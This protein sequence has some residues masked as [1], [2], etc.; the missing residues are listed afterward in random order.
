PGARYDLGA[1]RV[2]MSTGSPLSAE[3]FHWVYEAVKDDLQLASI[4]G[5]TDIISCFMLGCPTDPVYAGE[6]QK[7]GLGMRVE[8]WDETGRPVVGQ[9]GELVCTA[10]FVSMPVAFWNDPDGAR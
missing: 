7:R 9:K 2:V 4:S 1:L 8:A 3:L 6:I 5:G 10:P